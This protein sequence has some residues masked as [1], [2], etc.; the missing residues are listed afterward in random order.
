MA[1]AYLLDPTKQFQ[2]RAGV[3]NVAGWLEVFRMD[4]DDRA[5]VYADFSGT[6]QPEHILIDN[7]GRAVLIV[8]S[9][10]P[11]RVEMYLPN[12][13]LVYTQQPIYTQATG[14]GVSGV[15][16]VST[17]ESISIEKT[18]VGGIT[19]Y[20]LGLANDSAEGLEW[21][22]CSNENISNGA[23]YPLYG[24]GT[25]VVFPNQGLEVFADRCYHIT[26]TVKVDPTGT[27]VNYATLS[28]NL[29]F[30][31]GGEPVT[32]LR[33]N[34]DVDTSVNDPVL[35][36]FSY[37]FLP[38][39]YGFVFFNIEGV[40]QFEHVS[41]DMQ[42]HRV[43]SGMP[44]LPGN[45]QARLVPGP[46]IS[47]NGDVISV[48]ESFTQVQSDWDQTDPTAVDYIKNKPN[49]PSTLSAGD[50]IDITNNVITAK[51]DGTTVTINAD[52]ELQSSPAI[53]VDQTYDPT[54]AHP[55]SGVAIAGAL[56]DYTPTSSLATVATTGD[57]GDLLNT[58]SIPTATSDLQNDSGYITLSDVPA[59][60]Q[61]DW[62]ETDSSDP[63]YI[64][65]KPSLATVATSGS[66]T[67][68]SNTPDLSQYATTTDL[69]GKADKVTGATNGDI[70]VLDSNGN[71]TDTGIASANLVHDAS[72]V[73]T[74][75]NFTNADV[76]KLSGI[77]TGAEVN[78]QANWTETDTSSDAYIQNK[79]NLATVATSGSYADLSNTPS[80]PTATSDLT[81]DSGYITLSDVPAQ[82]QSDWTETDTSAASYI[83][84]KP[85]IPSTLSAGNGIDITSNVVSAKVD[86]STVT[87]NA[88]GEL[89][90]SPA[91]T[92]D[93]TYNA[94]S[95][96]PQS[97]TAVADALS[98]YT[99]TSSLASVAT[100]GSYADLSNT[101]TIP[102]ATSD[103]QNDSGFITLSDVP[104]Q[105][106]SDWNESD[107]SDP[108]YIQNKPAIPVLPTMK[109]LVAGTN[110]AIAEG[111]NTVTISATAAPQVQADWS[112]SDT[113]DVSYIQNKPD[114]SVYA[115]S[116]NLATVA[117][118]GDYTDLT[119]K[120]TIP[121]VPTTDQQYN[122]NS[123]NPQSGTA[124][125]E[126]IAGTGQV[127]TVTSSDND[128]VLTATYSGGV[129]SFA[130]QTPS[131]TQVQADWT[132]SDT[133]D[134]SYIQN[135]PN[136]ATVATSGDYNDLSNKPTIP[137]AQVNS[138]WSANSGVAQILNKPTVKPVLAGSNITIT[139]T[140]NDFTIAASVPVIGTIT[141]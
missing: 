108:A 139:E 98:D 131:T 30:T 7:N 32:V 103:L 126:A 112:E 99:P 83:Q 13:D 22:K 18:T 128:K 115:L 93:Q 26:C 114:L 3:N 125:A 16:L 116:A 132:E 75:N 38:S 92:V 57:Y 82:V 102:T 8:E 80:I 130:W 43:Y 39:A 53:T 86:G 90:A 73:H 89:Q 25:M 46:G 137:A 61:S 44:E 27:G 95:T 119:N 72:Y 28:A 33:R 70:A 23:V 106:Q 52:G 123:T 19:Q 34:Y 76:T 117:T 49:I 84:H 121:T 120:P 78:V 91:I 136:L 54:S 58:P 135:K 10:I 15:S 105:V 17:D 51:V 31:D 79:P 88:S 50:G 60:V 48:D 111:Q 68:L 110:I 94:S 66:Y 74:D 101:P 67:D 97:G 71:I 59:Q 113:S 124:V 35:C 133:T 45:I 6:L 63:A 42:V 37:D 104:A 9:G 14:G 5:T 29:M 69:S 141:V 138:D 40:A 41:V 36:E 96:N 55:Q 65:N 81:N 11:Y 87:I 21:V 109:E 118:S 24:E 107:T 12:G 134:P 100:S 20:D 47:I 127:P 62:T 85:T 129:G 64:A 140:A 4:T 1:L 2:N 56:A 77:A 122:P